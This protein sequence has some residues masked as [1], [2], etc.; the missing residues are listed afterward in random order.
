MGRVVLLGLFRMGKASKNIYSWTTSNS[1]F[2]KLLALQTK[3]SF[4]KSKIQYN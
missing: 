4:D 3:R 1:F 2:K